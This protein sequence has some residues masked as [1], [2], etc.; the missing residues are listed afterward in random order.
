M[1]NVLGS[2]CNVAWSSYHKMMTKRPHTTICLRTIYI[3]V[4][5]YTSSILYLCGLLVLV[6]WHRTKSLPVCPVIEVTLVHA[7]HTL[8]IWY[9]VAWSSFHRM[10]TKKPH[11][12]MCLRTIYILMYWYT[13]ILSIH[14]VSRSSF[15]DRTKI[16][17]I[18]KCPVIE[19]TIVLV[20]W[21]D[22]QTLTYW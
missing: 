9:T 15:Y 20:L 19:V 7:L 16:L 12:T 1:P 13:H 4:L 2:S 6:L 17:P 14:M 10:R 8:D 3:G 11:R 18:D 22:D 5:I 21:H